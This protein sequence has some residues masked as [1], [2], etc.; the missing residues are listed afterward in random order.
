[1]RWSGPIV[2]IISK[3]HAGGTAMPTTHCVPKLAA[4]VIGG[5][6]TF[7]SAAAAELTFD[8]NLARNPPPVREATLQLLPTPTQTANAVLRVQFQDRRKTGSLVIHGGKVPTLLRD[9]GT[10]PD[11]KRGDGVY[12]ALVNVNAAQFGVEQRRRLELAK[13]YREVPVFEQRQLKRWIPFSPSPDTQLNTDSPTTLDR[14]TGV[15]FL[16]D[17]WRELLIRN[18]GVVEDPART[19]DACTGEG[20]PMGAWTFG[21]LM[22]EMANE[23]MT[24]I[25]PGDFVQHWL[26][27]WTQDL[28]IN[29]WHVHNR[30]V[31]AQA[32]LDAW[33]KLP[34][35]QLDL[36]EAPFR[37]LAIV[38]RLDLRENSAYGGSSGG[39]ARFV[40]GLLNCSG[41]LGNFGTTTE[42]T[43]ILE[44]GIDKTGCFA[45]RNWAQQW[46]ALGELAP[47]S[48]AYN[49]ALQAITD[50]FTL[51][52]A[53]PGQLPNRSAIN[54]VRTNENSFLLPHWEL[55]EA[56]LCPARAACAGNLQQVTIAQ[57]PDV[58]LQNTTTLRDFINDKAVLILIGAHTVPLSY[59]DD[60]PF[61]GGAIQPG[62][63]MGWMNSPALVGTIYNLNARHEFSKAT[64]SGCHTRETDTDFVHIAKRKPGEESELSDFLTGDD[65]PKTDPVTDDARHF[66]ELLDR[67]AKLDVAANLTCGPSDFA[68]EELF[69]PHL[70]SGFVH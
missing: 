31:G 58:Q 45:V 5:V 21:R 32:L 25:A 22:T 24:G 13:S 7:T 34:N 12:A 48:A 62:S 63:G 59:P 47:G 28:T 9:D 55:R 18:L 38:N 30:A 67:Q 19:Y 54:Q 20:T 6:L 36:A 35:G 11:T 41:A 52:N 50:Q 3:G 49:A 51:S 16:V 1:M 64:C 46:Q 56:K 44:Y 39:E 69:I 8:R 26:E 14:F 10:A 57:T 68:A 33:P 15:P 65:M 60:E 2:Q 42:S 4:L 70:S 23:A 53:D 66:H 43:V 27:Q 40:F 61:R 37:L 17:P 29:G